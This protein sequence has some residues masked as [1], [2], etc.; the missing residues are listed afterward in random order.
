MKEG[1][2]DT[3]S[4]ILIRFLIKIYAPVLARA[5]SLQ[6]SH[7]QIA[8]PLNPLMTTLKVPVVSQALR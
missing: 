4:E 6:Y 2:N 3:I 8:T 5:T 1:Q 7:A